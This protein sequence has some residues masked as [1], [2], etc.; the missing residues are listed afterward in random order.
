MEKLP[1]RIVADRR[2]DLPHPRDR[3]NPRFLEV[4]D[5]T[6]AIL[7]GETQAEHVELGAAPGEAGRVRALPDV[8]VADL[9]GFL[10]RLAAAPKET[11]DIYKLADELQVDTNRL[12]ALVEAAEL[13]GFAMV[14]RGDIT[15]T[16]LGETF[17]DAS[18]LARKV[19]FGTRIRRLPF[20]KWL[21]TLLQ[22]IDE[23][24]LDRDDALTALEV[25]FPPQEVT[26]QLE[27]AVKWGRYAE[28]FAYDDATGRIF[29]EKTAEAPA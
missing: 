4:V 10:E 29:L 16:P 8:T 20:F 11:V 7:T 12:L 22:L 17:A 5:R 24:F 9:A 21:L 14:A 19:I 18:I 13:L 1:G 6:F 27:T 26:R 25:E 2:V 28:V 15:L 23:P 3:K